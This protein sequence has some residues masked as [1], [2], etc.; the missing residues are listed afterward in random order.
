MATD[1]IHIVRLPALRVASAY[2]FGF[3]PEE[4]A[5]NQLVQWAQPK[6][7]LGDFEAHPI[8]GFNN[9]YPTPESPKYGYV[10]WIGVDQTVEPE[11]TIRIEE[12]FGGSYAVSRCEVNGDPGGR[13][14]AKWKTLAEW[15][16]LN[17]Y[18]MGKHPALEQFLSRPDDIEHLVLNLYCPILEREAALA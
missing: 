7:L 17:H 2:G 4:H 14:P 18:T 12:F 8:F 5:W 6:G 10:F 15:C 13:I 1:D 11:G 3:Q 9:P 16:K